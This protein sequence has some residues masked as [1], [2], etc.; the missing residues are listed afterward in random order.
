MR[1]VFPLLVWLAACGGE[2]APADPA[3]PNEA[4]PA[5]GFL[6]LL[7][8]NASVVARAPAGGGEGVAGLLAMLGRTGDDPLLHGLDG[9]DGARASG[10]ALGAGGAWWLHFVPAADKGR[11]NVAL[12]ERAGRVA[13]REED[14][15][16]VL[17]TGGAPAPGEPEPLPPGR[18]AIRVVH[19]ALLDE[20]AQ[21]GDRLEFGV[22]LLEHGLQGEGRLTPGKASPTTEAI[23][24]AAGPIGGTLSGRL[25]ML[26][27]ALAVRVESTIPPTAY[28]TYLA[29]RIA[30]HAGLP[31]GE[32]RDNVERFLRE[33]ATGLD[34]EGGIA[35]GL[36]LAKPTLPG[37]VIVGRI[38]D[39]P[40]SP[41]LA[42]LR[43]A[44]RTTFGGLVLDAR[45]TGSQVIRGFFAW[46]PQAAPDDAGLPRTAAPALV[47]VVREDLGV[48]VAYA[49]AE[50]YG[51]VAAGGRADL[52][53]KAVRRR[54]VQG[55]TQSEGAR[56][57]A[58]LRERAGGECILAAVVAGD[59]FGGLA[60]E[61]AGALRAL[62]GATADG[63]PPDLVVVAGFRDDEEGLA[64][65]TEVHYR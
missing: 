10:F 16:I 43:R 63:R 12:R 36:D 38:A 33:A 53:A 4:P 56:V 31:D 22:D 24:R 62:L 21:P 46:A 58:L 25:D 1:A 59:R 47:S 8:E 55:R 7:P 42:K 52:L 18:A 9:R 45:D 49:E 48:P 39:G 29:R 19:H 3:A 11:M 32:L 57:L 50:G 61:D 60:G 27:A 34:P 44:P 13:V 35:F 51:I 15:W 17:G 65:R 41:V 23:A 54:V 5:D 64:L 2:P 30:R 37:F 40:A 14:D 26:P 6:R 28:A 20:I